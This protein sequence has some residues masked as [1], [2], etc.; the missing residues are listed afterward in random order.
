MCKGGN[1]KCKRWVWWEKPK[2]D[3]NMACQGGGLMSMDIHAHDGYAW[4][5]GCMI[6]LGLE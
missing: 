4:A 2:G 3:G 1:Q 5:W 6:A